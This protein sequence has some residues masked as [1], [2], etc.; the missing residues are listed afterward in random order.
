MDVDKLQKINM[1]A[2]EFKKHNFALSS[3]EAYKQA[4]QV[5]EQGETQIVVEQPIITQRK[6]EDTLETRKIELLL[7]MNNKKYEQEIHVL[8]NAVNMLA[9][10]LEMLKA[11]LQKQHVEQPKEKQAA[12]KTETKEDHPRQGK[13]QPAD[14]DIQKMF[15]FGNK[16]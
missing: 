14:V 5:Y 3:D 2:N 9:Q 6:Q 7:E 13:F 8:K 4:E 12:L 15:Y 11:E 1:L 10:E 16:R